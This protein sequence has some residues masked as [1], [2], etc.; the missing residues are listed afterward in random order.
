MKSKQAS[1]KYDRSSRLHLLLMLLLLVFSFAATFY[2]F[3]LPTDGWLA[4][5]TG[6]ANIGYIYKE[7]IMGV[8]S[9]LQPGDNLVGVEGITLDLSKTNGLWSL[10][11]LWVAGNQVRYTVIR[12]GETLEISVPLV[13]WQLSSLLHSSL[14]SVPALAH[15]LGLLIFLV[16]GFLVFQQRPQNPAARALL[17]LSA[18]LFFISTGYDALPPAVAHLVDPVASLAVTAI[19]F[20]TFTILLP[21]ALIRFALV[22]PHTKPVIERHPKLA[23]LPYAA[24]GLVMIAFFIKIYEVGFAWTALSVLLAFLILI[25]NAFTMRDAVSRAQLRWGAGGMIVGL[26]I[27]LLT[28]KHFFGILSDSAAT[29]ISSLSFLV[30]GISLAIAILR[31]R[32]WDIDLII[33]KT[34]QYAILTALLALVYFGS[35]ILLQSLTE[36]LFAEQSPFVIVLST[37]AIAALFNP[38]RTRIQDFID[39]RFY[40]KKY[41]AEQALAQFAATARDEV[42]MEKLTAALLRVVDESVQ[43]EV[44]SLWLEASPDHTQPGEK[45]G[46]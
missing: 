18:A 25:H 3:T 16:M 41:N 9:E 8:V 34:L 38:L 46:L 15:W 13:H 37:L 26:G 7:N 35:V 30:M 24:G 22:F 14:F 6:E 4:V 28:D 36:N 43:P 17:I 23:L 31:Y 20:V 42:D 12:Q 45:H 33:R 40:R 10:K 1:P 19:I 39:R 2:R 5:E 44:V 27:I 32:L 11:P 29:V 21:P